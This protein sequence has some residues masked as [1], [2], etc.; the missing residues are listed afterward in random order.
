MK[1][2]WVLSSKSF[3]DSNLGLVHTEDKA[4]LSES[5]Q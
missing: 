4:T 5:L 1:G 2:D 3:A